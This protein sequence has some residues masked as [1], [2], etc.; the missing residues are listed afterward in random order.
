MSR[1]ILLS[2][3][4]YFLA[5]AMAVIARMFGSFAA[6]LAQLTLAASAI[7]TVGQGVDGLNHA[8]GQEPVVLAALPALPDQLKHNEKYA[9]SSSCRDCHPDQYESWHRSYHR[10]MTQAASP[11]NFVGR[12]DGTRVDSNGLPYRVFTRNGQFWAE[13]PDPDEM[14]NRQRTYEIKTQHG[15]YT[16]PLTWEGIPQVERQ[17][18]MS[19]GSHHYQTYWVESAKY[20][21]T[22][23]TL[24]LVY[25]IKDK[26]WIPR[27][28]AFM[29]PPGPRRMVTVW[30]DHCISCHSTGPA[31]KPYD[32][33]DPI[34]RRILETGF[35]SEVGEIGIACEACHG[36]AQEHVRLRIANASGDLTATTEKELLKDPIVQPELLDD[37]RRTSYL[38]GQC[39]GVY[40]R[41]GEQALQYRDEGLDYVPGDDLLAKRYYIFPPQDESFYPD[42]ASRLEAATAFERNR[43]F[44]R[45]RF[46]DNG[47]VL[48]GG[49][50]FTALAVSKCFT[51]GTISCLSCH[52]MHQSDP[53]DQLKPGM[54]T[55]AACI[56]CHA[57]PKFDAAVSEHA[58]HE[59]GSS[60]SDCLN[61]HMP[62]T[63]Y[64]LFTAIR[65]HQIESPDLAGSVKHGVPNA[66]NLCHL[67]KTL[68]WTQE[69]LAE[70]YGY[71]SHTLSTEQ[72][73]VSAALVWML[74]GDAAQRVITS[75]HVGWKPAQEASGSDWLAPFVARLLDD[76]YGVVRY[77]SGRS[78]ATLPKFE[79]FKYD[80][81]APA[82]ERAAAANTVVREW[83]RQPNGP[84]SRIGQQVLIAS[85]GKVAEPA[86]QWL[87]KHRDNRPV[88]IKE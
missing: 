53:N 48:A 40:I 84:P 5:N 34:N 83:Q 63:T 36:P 35:R 14:L 19:T 3:P 26:Q 65:S 39:H 6:R 43:N 13:M 25:L 32:R 20:P 81:L 50:E 10:T 69:H 59:K 42:E 46:W 49:R 87:L 86:V 21:G 8:C 60:G 29:Y 71:E 82:E 23:M 62:R 17:V 68:A 41:S 38:C 70:W 9:S 72:E 2:P 79:E 4:A 1:D 80:F 27:E 12:F 67:D 11:E 52:S 55:S 28:A 7:L 45:E 54:E 75:W 88:T 73:K 61:C 15:V 66:C 85:D 24:P 33:T 30:N 58:H 18:V 57:E 76:P 64:A 78:L 31:P 47:L 74:K 22:L 56:E 51:K 37:H 16:A 44:F 77:V